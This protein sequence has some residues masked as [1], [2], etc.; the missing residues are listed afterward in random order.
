M[1]QMTYCKFDILFRSL[2]V[3]SRNLSA[4]NA[5]TVSAVIF[6]LTHFRQ[7]KMPIAARNMIIS[8]GTFSP[9]FKF[10][11]IAL[12]CEAYVSYRS[13]CKPR[14]HCKHLPLP[15]P[16]HLE[17]AFPA[18]DPLDNNFHGLILLVQSFIIFSGN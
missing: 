5:V 4:T 7:A 12:H 9:P 3:G 16:L 1:K 15:A 14:L 11:L 18:W 8:A 17:Q 13:E 6:H 2:S 10:L